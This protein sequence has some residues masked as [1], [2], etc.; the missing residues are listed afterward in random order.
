MYSYIGVELSRTQELIALPSPVSS[1]TA[2][3]QSQAT[4]L[5]PEGPQQG[6][7]SLRKKTDI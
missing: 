6:D 3:E 7:A 4:Y 1:R 2:E 5:Q